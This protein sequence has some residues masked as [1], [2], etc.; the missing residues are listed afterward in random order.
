MF[1]YVPKRV[2]N[3]YSNICTEMLTGVFTIAKRGGKM[4]ISIQLDKQNVNRHEID[5]Y[6]PIKRNEVLIHT[7][8][9][10]NIDEN[11]V[12]LKEAYHILYDSSYMIYRE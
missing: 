1:R 11:T 2:K 9:W 3:R 8:T 7:T 6:S 10:M 4:S 5:Y 12:Q